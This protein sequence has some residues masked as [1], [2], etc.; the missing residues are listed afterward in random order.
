[1]D[2]AKRGEVK[3]L[4]PYEL[5]LIIDPRLT[6]D[7][8]AQLLTRLGDSLKNLGAEVG[9]V[10]NWGRRR[11]AYDIRKQREGTYAVVEVSAE[12]AMVRE[13]ER[14]LKLNESVLRFLTTRVPARRK[15]RPADTQEALEE[16]G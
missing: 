6:D 10:E 7:E 5:L 2:S 3:H 15:P 13:F 4:R 1:M 16:V 14:Q 11:L 12:P 9:Q 8:A